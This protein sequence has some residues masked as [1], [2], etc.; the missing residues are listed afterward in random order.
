[1]VKKKVYRSDS[2]INLENHGKLIYCLG[3]YDAIQYQNSTF[4][5]KPRS[6]AGINFGPLCI[7][8]QSIMKKSLSHE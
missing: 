7:S 4:K 6:G 1:M 3:I 8:A 2:Q 5:T